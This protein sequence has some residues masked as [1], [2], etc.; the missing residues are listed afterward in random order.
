M[1]KANAHST[2]VPKN[3]VSMIIGHSSVEFEHVLSGKTKAK[4]PPNSNNIMTTKNSGY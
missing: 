3:Q 1:V 4:S 2:F